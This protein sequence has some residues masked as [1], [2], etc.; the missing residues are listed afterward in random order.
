MLDGDASVD[1]EAM[2][3]AR[4]HP[5]L[6]KSVAESKVV[7][8]GAVRT[9]AYS[10]LRAHLR[11]VLHGMK[12]EVDLRDL[13]LVLDRAERLVDVLILGGLPF[14]LGGCACTC[15]LVSMSSWSSSR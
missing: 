14:H 9:F 12:R 8:V 7:D 10:L 13:L 6:L 2:N 11:A 3:T 1:G 5:L 4:R 15:S